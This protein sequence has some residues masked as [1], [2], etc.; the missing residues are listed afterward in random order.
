MDVTVIR[1]DREIAIAASRRRI[2]QILVD[3]EGMHRW[4]PARE[5]VRRRPGGPDPDG[6]GAVRVVRV[7][8]LAIEEVVTAFKREE[9]LEYGVSAGAPV[10]DCRGEVV[11]TPA[12][13]NTLVRWTVTLRPLVPGSGWLL[14]RVVS[15]LLEDSLSGLAFLAESE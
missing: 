8:G 2:W 14:R 1:I 3:H 5:V 10:R 12:R 4:T 7:A 15:R 11:L 6:V 13:G 9:R